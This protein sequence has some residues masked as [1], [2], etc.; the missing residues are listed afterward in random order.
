M[1][2]T[3]RASASFMMSG[4][5]S[6]I[7]LSMVTFDEQA[8]LQGLPDQVSAVAV[9]LDADHHAVAADFRHAR[10]SRE[11]LARPASRIPPMR[12]AFFMRPSSSMAASVA[13]AAAQASG[14]PPNVEP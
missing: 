12:S 2:S 3:W 13:R 6:R 1:E 5:S 10:T 7:T 9:E 11:A 8:R 14:L 4:G